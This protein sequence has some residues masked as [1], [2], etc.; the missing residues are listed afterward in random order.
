MK[1]D[2]GRP[3]HTKEVNDAESNNAWAPV[4]EPSGDLTIP[5]RIVLDDTVILEIFVM[6]AVD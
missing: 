6:K 3:S 1:R 4:E 5:A 2:Q